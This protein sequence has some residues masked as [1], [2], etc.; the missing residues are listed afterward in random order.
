M[1]ELSNAASTVVVTVRIPVDIVN[2]IDKAMDQRLSS[3]ATWIR[4]TII[5][6]L[7]EEQVIAPVPDRPR[8]MA[9]AEAA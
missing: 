5:N 2:Y 7:R 8:T 3:R 4:E 1:I 9:T 6:R